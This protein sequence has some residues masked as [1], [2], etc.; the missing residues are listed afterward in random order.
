MTGAAMRLFYAGIASR[1]HIIS[2]VF[3]IPGDGL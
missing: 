2:T 1:G 3:L